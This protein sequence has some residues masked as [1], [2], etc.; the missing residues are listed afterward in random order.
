MTATHVSHDDA[1]TCQLFQR[2]DAIR[3][4]PADN[5]DLASSDFFL[6]GSIKWQLYDYNYKNQKDILNTIT[7]S[8]IGVDQE[9]LLSVF[10]SW[11]NQLKWVIKHEGKYCTI[12]SQR[13]KEAFL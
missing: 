8:F 1:S 11:I 3:Q 2:P 12:L 13:K 6:F 10:E 7:E 4:H 5:T 9:V